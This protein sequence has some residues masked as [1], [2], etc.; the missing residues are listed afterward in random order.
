MNR[1]PRPAR[2]AGSFLCLAAA[3][4]AAPADDVDGDLKLLQGT[5]SAALPDGTSVTFEFNDKKVV[6]T[7]GDMVIES[8]LELDEKA[9]PNKTIDFKIETGP[10]DIVGLTAPGIYKT[11]DEGKKVTICT[12]HPG[13][14][15]PSDFQ[16]EEGVSVL[17]ELTKDGN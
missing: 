9:E 3:L 6:T 17:F 2:I 14:E 11:S 16:D 7:I 1:A 4:A 10:P 15:R 8:T 5:W 13:T 12:G